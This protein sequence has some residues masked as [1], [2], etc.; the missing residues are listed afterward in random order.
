MSE[1]KLTIEGMS[2]Q[3]CVKRVKKAIDAIDGVEASTVDVGSASVTIN[4]AKTSQKTV[5]QAITGAG[6]KVQ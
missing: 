6:Y 1:I 5:E 3:H 2:C 4:D